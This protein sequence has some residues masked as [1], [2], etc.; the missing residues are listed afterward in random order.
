VNVRTADL[1]PGNVYTLWWIIFDAPE[2]CAAGPDN[3][4][5]ADI[6]APG[7]PADAT[8]FG[9]AAGSLAGG[10]GTATFAGHV[11]PGDE[12]NF[13]DL[14]DGSVD[15]P[16][17]ADVA[18]VVRNHGPA[19]PGSVSEQLSTFDGGCPPNNCMNVQFGIF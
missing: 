8:V 17:S 18:F 6:F 7:N 15:D 14:G 13:I 3:C 1:H 2:G 16:L 12:P 19:I 4:T 9:P 11:G 10:S 5:L